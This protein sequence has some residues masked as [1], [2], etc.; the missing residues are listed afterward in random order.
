[1]RDLSAII[2]NYNGSFPNWTGKNA[3]GAGAVDG[4]EW[5]AAII[6]DYLWGWTQRAM[7]LAGLTPDGVAES[8]SA[9]Q[10]VDALYRIFGP[11]GTICEWNLADDPA[12]YGARFLFLNGQGIL[13]ANYADLDAN[14][15]VGDGNNAT[16]DA[17]YHADDAAGTTRNTTGAYLI[18]PE[19][20]G[21]T[22]RGLDTAASVDPDGASRTLGD[23]QDDAFQDHSHLTTAGSGSGSLQGFDKGALRASLSSAMD[24]GNVTNPTSNGSGTPR[25]DTETR[26]VNRS[27]QFAIRY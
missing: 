25:T 16:A 13:R 3:T 6:D 26:M 23:N 1:M 9:S 18:L 19:S 17:Y 5:V 27:T 22:T 4:T 10:V 11:P 2:S 12:T 21:Y 7:N 8:S 24:Q 20:R 15:Y 14:V